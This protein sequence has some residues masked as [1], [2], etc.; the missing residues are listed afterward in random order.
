MTF[1]S[2]EFPFSGLKDL[3]SSISIVLAVST[4][5]FSCNGSKLPQQGPLSSSK[6]ELNS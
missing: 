6:Q 5:L 2:V 3:R 1:P 4:L